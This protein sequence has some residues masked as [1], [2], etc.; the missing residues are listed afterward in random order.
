MGITPHPALES[1]P[2]M[3]SRWEGAGLALGVGRIGAI[4]HTAHVIALAESL[5][6]LLPTGVRIWGR[7][8]TRQALGDRGCPMSDEGYD[9][10]SY[11]HIWV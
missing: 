8:G 7:E 9:T 4:E 1:N 10:W 5:P 11:D 2:S 6:A 3:M